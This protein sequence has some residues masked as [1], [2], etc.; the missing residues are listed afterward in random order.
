MITSRKVFCILLPAFVLAA[1][2]TKKEAPPVV[3]RVGTLTI[4]ADEFHRRFETT[5]RLQQFKD[6]EQAKTLFLNSLIAEKLL[7]LEAAQRRLLESPRLRAFLAQIHREATIEELF[8]EKVAKPNRGQQARLDREIAGDEFMKYF[9]KI[10]AG[11]KTEV[12]PAGFKFLTERLEEI[13]HIGEDATVM[14]RKLNPSPLSTGEF[15]QAGQSLQASLDEILVR[16]D[17]DS[18]WAI[19]EILQRLSV[20]MYHLDFSNRKK[21]RLSL[22]EALITMIEQEYVYKAAVQEGLDKSPEVAAE[23]VMWRENMQAQLLVQR[24]AAAENE[25]DLQ[26][27]TGEQAEL[28][29]KTL[30]ALAETHRIEI[31]PEILH[32]TPVSNAGLLLL[33]THFPGRMVT[34]PSL[35]LEHLTV[36]QEK[37]AAKAKHE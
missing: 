4:T 8:N 9:K 23:V 24:L 7:A 27:P 31:N 33:K 16:F 1:A 29:A 28:V 21:F 11:K 20:G 14:V 15:S 22:R 2:C 17:D 32:R 3:A 10:M 35:P 6:I 12:P 37:V 25:M 30:L 5:P 19:K 18:D 26:T 34:P 36:W 13:F